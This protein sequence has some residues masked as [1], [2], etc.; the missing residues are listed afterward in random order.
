MLWEKWWQNCI[1]KEI[2]RR[3]NME[4][5]WYNAVQS[6]LLSWLL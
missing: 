6:P 5:A 1:Y 2:K 4:N 3:L